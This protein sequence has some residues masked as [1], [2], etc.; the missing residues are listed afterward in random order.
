MLLSN[1][2]K[3]LIAKAFAIML[4]TSACVFIYFIAV[5]ACA[6]K[7]NRPLGVTE[8]LLTLFVMQW[9]WRRIW[10]RCAK[11]WKNLDA[12]IEH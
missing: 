9:V 4:A 1:R 2:W 7:T 10:K 12:K 8:S 3:V 5:I 11:I 6:L